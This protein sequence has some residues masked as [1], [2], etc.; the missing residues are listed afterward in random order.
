MAKFIIEGGSSAQVADGTQNTLTKLV[1]A[2]GSGRIRIGAED[3]KEF[4]LSYGAG[5][6][7]VVPAL[8]SATI[9][10]DSITDASI[11]QYGGQTY[12]PPPLPDTKAIVS[13]DD[14]A[15]VQNSAGAAIG[16]GTI[17]VADNEISHVRLPATIASLSNGDSVSV[18][19]SDDADPHTG[20]A[21]VS[22]GVLTGINLAATVAMIDNS[23]SV[24]VRN[25]AGANV[26]A[27]TAVVASGVIT[28][29]ILAATVAIIDNGETFSVDGGT[30][31]ISVAD[32][33]PTVT[34]TPTP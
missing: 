24:P 25:Y 1:I 6:S 15:P 32:G 16:T 9:L 20:T 28:S 3:A 12:D 31:S 13:D 27:A 17:T 23:D 4:L 11:G 21:V 8:Q 10:A 22:D 19:N 18:L 26:H 29:V 7:V 14:T 34:F 5:D 30:V 2:S 33:V